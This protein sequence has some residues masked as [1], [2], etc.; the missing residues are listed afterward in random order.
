[1]AE[2]LAFQERV[3]RHLDG[4]E[5]G[6]GEEQVDALHAVGHEEGDALPGGDTGLGQ[7][8]RQPGGDVGRLPVRPPLPAAGHEPLAPLFPGPLVE[9]VGHRHPPHRRAPPVLGVGPVAPRR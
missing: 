8:R 4:A 2:E 6:A 7:R 3:E 9:Q 5:P 1:M